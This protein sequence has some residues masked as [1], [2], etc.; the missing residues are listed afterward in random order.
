MMISIVLVLLALV[1]LVW[2]LLSARDQG[3]SISQ[4]SE[5]RGRT[6]VVDL[7]AFR[8]LVDPAEREYLQEQL[9]PAEF[10]RIQRERLRAAVKYIDC[11]ADNAA[12]LVRL[13]Q[14]ARADADATVAQA[15][16]QLVN[17]ALRVRIYAAEARLRL[18]GAIAIPSLPYGRPRVPESYEHLTG[19]VARL[20]MLQ[21]QR[22]HVRLSAV[23]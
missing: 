13:G 14:A 8:N 23:L 1:A 20:G 15:A 19:M 5:L 16:A 2:F 4:V 6:Q 7:A 10:R 3:S 12:I 9:P 18:Y 22:A 11:V 21:K 17:N